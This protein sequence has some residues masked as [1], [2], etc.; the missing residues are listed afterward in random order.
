MLE[1]EVRE[2]ASSMRDFFAYSSCRVLS[3]GPR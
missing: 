3:E 1:A 2:A